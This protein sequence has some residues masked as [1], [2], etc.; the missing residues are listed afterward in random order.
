[1]AVFYVDNVAQDTLTMTKGSIYRFDQ[2][3]GSN[4]AHPLN[5]S[6][7]D[8]G[9]NNG[10]AAYATG[11]S[12]WLNNLEVNRS[13]YNSGFGGATSRF[14]QIQVDASAPA[15]LY[16]YAVGTASMGGTINVTDA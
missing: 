14:L 6:T 5:L 8:D 4:S 10:G 7:T 15:T 9:E 11:V 1:M 16:Y 3:N 2:N 13:T 12:Y